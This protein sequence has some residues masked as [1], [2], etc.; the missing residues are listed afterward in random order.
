MAFLLGIGFFLVYFVVLAPPIDYPQG[1]YLKVKQGTTVSQAAQLLKDKHLIRSKAVFEGLV[2]LVGRN[3][4][5]AGEYFFPSRQSAFTVARRLA[6]GDYE[7]TPMRMVF[8][9]GLTAAQMAKQLEKVPDF[10]EEGFLAEA[11]PKEGYLF[12][13]TYFVLPGEDYQ[14]LLSAMQNNFDT[15][16]DSASTT[17]AKFGKPLNEVIVMASLLER[18]A[19]DL[20]SRRIIAGILW[21]RIDI[22]MLLQVDAVF[23]Y[24]IGKNTFEVTRE[25]LKVD[26]PYNT[27]KYK[28]LPPGAIANPGFNSILAAVTPVKSNYLFYLSDR[29]GN[30]HYCATYS[31]HQANARKYLG[32]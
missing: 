3:N 28:G 8:Y 29:Q 25:D 30:F 11:K 27:Y 14:T 19:P 17:I 31:C 1:T 23:P 32:N 15:H 21:H 20:E 9:E 24:I 6:Y 26:S 16:I 22:G 12:P 2:R 7:V 13:D 5:Y 10:D 4:I 18:E